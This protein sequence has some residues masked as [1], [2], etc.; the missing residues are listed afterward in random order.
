M[1]HFFVTLQRF[2]PRYAI[3]LFINWLARV[4][5]PAV[6]NT[7]IRRFIS[8]YDVETHEL[9]RQ[10]PDGYVTFNDFFV[11]PLVP[12]AR[13]IDNSPTSVVSPVDGT[14]SAA[15]KIEKDRLL[16]AKHI[17]YSLANL[18]VTNTADVNHYSNGSFVT[19]YLAPKNY[20]RV[21]APLS[22]H[23]RAARY[24]PGSLFSVNNVTVQNLSQLFVR[25]ER[26]ICHLDTDVGGAVLI[27]IGALNVGTINTIWTGDLK[28]RRK[29]VIEDIDLSNA[30]SELGF[31]KGALLGW[32]NMGSTVI[33]LFPPKAVNG[34]N[35]VECG[36][37]VRMGEPI[38]NLVLQK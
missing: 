24:V 36:H 27:L 34:F 28:P 20:H 31:R 25:N 2:L 18:L 8:H 3:T 16:Q 14:I 5:I 4:R 23:V 13:P 26:L 35:K 32:F 37:S 7:L 15:G 9:N 38:G 17:D 11:R 29:G 30:R 12:G 1:S 19:I 33:L 6:K 21:H 22:G 10:V